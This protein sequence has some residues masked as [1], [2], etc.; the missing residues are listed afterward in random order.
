MKKQVMSMAVMVLA[1]MLMTGYSGINPAFAAQPATPAQ[2]PKKVFD[3]HDAGGLG[4]AGGNGFLDHVSRQ[5]RQSD[6][7]ALGRADGSTRRAGGSQ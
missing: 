7:L 6:Q 3:A 1:A 4:H 2:E 5:H